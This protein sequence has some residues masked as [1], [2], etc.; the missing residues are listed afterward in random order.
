MHAHAASGQHH[1][2]HRS[3]CPGA[4]ALLAELRILVAA[5]GH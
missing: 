2:G 3:G 4:S 5:A 1:G